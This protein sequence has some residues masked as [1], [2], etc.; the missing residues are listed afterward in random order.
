MLPHACRVDTSRLC[1][2]LSTCNLILSRPSHLLSDSASPPICLLLLLAGWLLC[3]QLLRASALRHILSRSCLTHPSSTP[4]LR[5]HQLVVAPH[6]FARPPPLNVPPPD[7][8]LCHCRHRCAG[9]VAVDAQASLPLLLLRLSPSSLIVE[10][11]SLPPLSLLLS[12]STKSI[13]IVII[14]IIVSPCA[15]AIIVNFVACRLSRC[16]HHCRLCH[17]LR[18]HHRCRRRHPLCHHH[19]HRHRCSLRRH[20]HGCCGW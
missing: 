11:A 2:H 5:S 15:V 8:W 9:V 1:L 10:L 12:L 16:C 18:R 13:A 14:I 7:G 3:R 4:L 6:L 19:R 17:L 20:N